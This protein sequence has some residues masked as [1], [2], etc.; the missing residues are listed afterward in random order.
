MA[1]KHRSVC[2]DIGLMLMSYRF[3]GLRVEQQM[4]SIAEKGEIA[5]VFECGHSL[6]IEQPERLANL[7][8]RLVL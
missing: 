7:L 4:K 2:T 5:E 6:A 8:I 3:F 1:D